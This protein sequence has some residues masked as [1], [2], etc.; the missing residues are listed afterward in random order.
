MAARISLDTQCHGSN[1]VNLRI[2]RTLQASFEKLSYSWEFAGFG[3]RPM[4]PKF[5]TTLW[6]STDGGPSL[7]AKFFIA[8]HEDPGFD[9]L[10]G[11]EDCFHLNLVPAA[12][13]PLLP[14]RL[15]NGIS[16]VSICE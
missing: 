5:E 8:P 3:G 15:K 6:F 10:L 7:Q 16:A 2:V 9:L 12:V 14:R 13:L 11:A 1:W 4:T